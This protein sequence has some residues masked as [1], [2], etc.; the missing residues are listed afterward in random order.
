MQKNVDFKLNV[1][2]YRD[3]VYACF[4]GKNIGG[5]VGGPYEG[6]R[7]ILDV[8]GF[9]TEPGV[10]LPNDDLD[11]QLVW[12]FGVER[13]GIS[14][15]NA[16]T[17]GE[18]WLSFIPAPWQEYG[19]CKAN[20]R[21]GL[22]PPIAGDYQNTWKHSNGAWIRTEVWSCMA[23]G[24]PAI[25]AKYAV[26]DAK[27]DHGSGEGT[28]AAAFVAAM[29]SAAFVLRDLRACIELALNCIPAASRMAKSIRLVLD[30]YDAGKEA[31]ETRNLVQESNRDIGDGWFEA[32]SNVAYAVIGLLYG[33]GDFKKS[34]LTAINCGDDTDCTASTVGATF[35]I[36]GGTAGIPED[37]RAYIGDEIVTI[38][39]DRSGILR[40]TPS[41]CQELT[42]RIAAQAPHVLFECG[43]ETVLWDGATEIPDNVDELLKKPC[44]RI[45]GMSS[46][47]PYSM[48][49]DGAVL[50]AD[51]I[52]DG[53][54][55][56]APNGERKVK[57]VLTNQY[58]KFGRVF[59]YANL[60]WWLP[61][62]FSI[63]GD[64]KTVQ[65][66][67]N[68]YSHYNGVST[69][70]VTVRAGE[71]VEAVNRIVLEVTL[72]GRILPLY[73]PINFLS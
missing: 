12:L 17:L 59:Y 16:A 28:Y 42:D 25:A 11:L 20:M 47:K 15:I 22:I 14:A 36:L 33:E 30:S 66:S 26:E 43:G 24:C 21:R 71:R 39:I 48:H 54:P 64:K 56:I 52:L 18:L 68:D 34:M 13:L 3:K 57:I 55:E 29:Q 73:I 58:D 32:P 67:T 49:F 35:G 4:I 61:D 50:S 72:D 40:R 60:R 53:A 8:K 65:I 51:V 7:E 63:E 5:T 1:Q 9:T 62:G 70:E 69:V 46:V 38:S 44:G 27:V 45:R 19:I 2:E 10:P 37:W 41:T 6:K 31:M 23:P